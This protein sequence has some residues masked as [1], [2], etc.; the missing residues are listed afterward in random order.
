MTRLWVAIPL[1]RTTA[2]SHDRPRREDGAL[3]DPDRSAREAAA[4]AI[5]FT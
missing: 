1:K 2:A 4:V 3:N 5:V